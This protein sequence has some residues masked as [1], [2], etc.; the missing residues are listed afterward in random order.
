[1]MSAYA[2]PG[3][4]PPLGSAGSEDS[5]FRTSPQEE[6]L[7]TRRSSFAGLLMASVDLLSVPSFTSGCDRSPDGASRTSVSSSEEP[8]ISVTGARIDPVRL[9]QGPS[10][11]PR[12]R[13]RRESRECLSMSCCDYSDLS[14]PNADA[15]AFELWISFNGRSYAATRSLQS[16]VQLR[17]DLHREMNSWCQIQARQLPSKERNI[18]QMP[19]I[20]PFCGGEQKAT[21]PFT[22]H[23]FT[24]LHAMA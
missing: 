13:R 23:G 15:I 17:D 9:I 5:R 1:M 22:G 12:P 19:N 4:V 10:S 8:K 20:P 7:K 24:L 18:L 3:L 6:Q 14:I 21:C 11:S 2:L 16:I